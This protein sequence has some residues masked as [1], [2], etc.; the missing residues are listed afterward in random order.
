MTFPEVERLVSRIAD[1]PSCRLFPPAGLPDLT[2][3]LSLPRD[4][5]IFYSLC[6]GADLFVGAAYNFRVLPRT[7][8]RNANETLLG[9]RFTDDLSSSWFLVAREGPEQHISIDLAPAR[10]GRC[11]DSFHET[12]A[13]RGSC[14]VV[15]TSFTTLLRHLFDARGERIY[16][17]ADDFAALGDAYES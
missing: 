13:V 12:H 16:W 14:P 1:E 11:Y 4:L 5:Q 15:A 2:G 8:F 9:D 7:E 6:G 10:L 17:L 3:G